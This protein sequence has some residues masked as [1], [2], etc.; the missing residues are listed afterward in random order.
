MI[1][2]HVIAKTLQVFDEQLFLLRTHSCKDSSLDA[3]AVKDIGKPGS[4]KAK[5]VSFNGYCEAE[6]RGKGH[7]VSWSKLRVR[8]I[9][10]F[11]FKGDSP[12]QGVAFI[13]RVITL[14]EGHLWVSV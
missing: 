2:T 6:R 12:I 13:S 7:V 10:W 5:T 1:L 9:P 4:D 14:E 3:D 8:A 11:H